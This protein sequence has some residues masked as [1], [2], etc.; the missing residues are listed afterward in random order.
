MNSDIFSNIIVF[1]CII[2]CIKLF[3][4]FNTDSLRSFRYSPNK[5]AYNNFKSIV[6]IEGKSLS[7]ISERMNVL[8]TKVEVFEDHKLYYWNLTSIILVLR[9]SLDDICIGV[10][11]DSK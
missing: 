1:L 8:P 4:K 2:I 10:E 9:F 3:S 7:Y 11:D 6:E 5:K